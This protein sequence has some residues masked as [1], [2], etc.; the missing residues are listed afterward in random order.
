MKIKLKLSPSKNSY[1]VMY[2]LDDKN[3]LL[4]KGFKTLDD[5]VKEVTKVTG[6]I[7]FLKDIQK[8]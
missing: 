3:Y 1:Q 4:H 7:R 8:R 5:A 2:S 6:S